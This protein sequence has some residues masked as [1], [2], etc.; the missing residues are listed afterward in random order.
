V[1]RALGADEVDVVGSV[2]GLARLHQGNGEYL[3]AWDGAEPMGHVHVTRTEPPEL[4]DLEVREGYRRRG[5][6]TARID[7]AESDVAGRGATRVQVE[8]SVDN[9]VACALYAAL[10]Y[11]D[12]G[13]PPR[14]VVGT[15]QLRTGPIE[16]DDT[17][18]T[19]AKSLH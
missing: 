13:V 17:L 10:G 11:V 12:S 8:V 6:A 2:L 16:V 18:R 15:I 4:Q 14:R 9:D 19:L 3:V 7:A 1:I 5:V